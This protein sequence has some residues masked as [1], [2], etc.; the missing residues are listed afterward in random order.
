MDFDFSLILV[1]VVGITGT[2]YL[3]DLLIFRPLRR[4]DSAQYKAQVGSHADQSVIDEY[5]REPAWIEYPKAFFP[6]LFVVLVLRSFLFEP[7]KIPSGSMNPTL[8]DGDYILVN[9]YTYGIRLPVIGTEV[10]SVGLPQRGDILVF[11]YP[12]NPRINYIKRVV[13]IPGDEI[14]YD[15]KQLY[16][17]GEKIEPEFVA[18]L[19]PGRPQYKIYTETL[20]EV[21]HQMQHTM[22]RPAMVSDTW[23]VG[24]G[25]YFVLG[26]NRDNSKDS[27]FWN[28]VP[29][30][31]IV[32][33]AFA[34]W[35][36]MPGW[37]FPSFDRNQ[38]LD[39]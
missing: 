17:N 31:N 30:E 8:L 34:I 14:R 35:M 20:G 37:S 5:E 10:I 29:E 19:Q 24:E 11:R 4:K 32:G 23:V 39:E 7:F 25:Q 36:H 15:N 18:Q 16:I 33:R 12:E 22:S 2:V 13:G 3:L 28:F 21:K 38:F 9:K 1:I 26:D 27:R 6:V